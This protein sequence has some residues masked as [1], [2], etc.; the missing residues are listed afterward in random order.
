VVEHIGDLL[1]QLYLVSGQPFSDESVWTVAGVWA[2]YFFAFMARGAIGFGAI[3]PA[4]TLSSFLIA[5]QHAVLLAILTATVPQLQLLP[6]GIRNGDWQV[7]KPVITALLVT[8]VIGVWL[9]TKIDARWFDLVLGCAMSMI[10]ILDST[11]VLERAAA[12]Y[13]LR[14]PKVA[15]GLSSV[16]GLTA[17]VAGAGGLMLFAVYLKHACRD[18]ISLRATAALLG[19][20]LIVWRLIATIVAGLITVKLVAEAALMLPSIFV[21][22]WIGSHY[23]RNMDAKRYYNLFQAV[24]LISAVGLMFQGIA[25]LF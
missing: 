22:V 24:L 3:A 15:F 16:A 6:D 8:I 20:V 11:R 12:R 9:F 1:R 21:G 5:P 23:F 10:V 19:T 18:Y 25:K 2:I 17:G 7:G 4:V 14:S 13:D